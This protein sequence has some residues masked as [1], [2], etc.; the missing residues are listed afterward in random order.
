MSEAM[1]FAAGFVSRHDAGVAAHLAASLSDDFA[2]QDMRA[3]AS[4]S[5]PRSAAAAGPAPKSFSPQPI[6]PKHFAPADREPARETEAQDWDVR[7]ADKQ[8]FIDPIAA[9]RAEGFAEG[10]AHARA[11]VDQD[12]DRSLGLAK[13]IAAALADPARIDREALAEQLRQTVMTLVGKVVG[14]VGVAPERLAERIEA[15][16]GLLADAA[17]SALLRV[18]P[19]DVDLLKPLLPDTIFPVGDAAIERGGFVLESAST[20]VEEGPS[21][22]MDQ[23]A[24]AIERVALPSC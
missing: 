17:E 10:L 23:L 19:D 4:R 8:G 13:A 11:M 22:W 7:Q 21:Q 24:A 14:E 16:A 20:I 5:K 1:G 2:P 15:A 18:H 12:H 6:G 3:R 9:A